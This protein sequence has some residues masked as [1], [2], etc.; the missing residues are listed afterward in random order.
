MDPVVLT[1]AYNRSQDKF[2]LF[3][4]IT[5]LGQKNW[6]F[7]QKSIPNFKHDSPLVKLL[8]SK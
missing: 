1:K 4:S 2:Y 8:P 3:H 7:K 5:F 6:S